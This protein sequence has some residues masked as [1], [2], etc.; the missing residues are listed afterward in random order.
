VEFCGGGRECGDVEYLTGMGARG[1]VDGKTYYLGND[2]LLE[3]IRVSWE[4]R[5]GQFEAL[6]NE[7]KTVL[8]LFDRE[9]V[10]A[11][12]AL[13]D[14]LK[15]GSIEAVAGLK[16]LNIAPHMLTGDN[17]AVAG[18]IAEQAGI[19]AEFVNAE[20]LPAD[21]L[22]AIKEQKAAPRHGGK[23]CVAMIGD[24]INDSPALKEADVG[25]AMGNG[26]DVAIE[27]ADIVLV[28]GDLRA[29]VR[30]FALS[31]KAMR[32]IK[33]NLFWAFF[34]NCIGIPL[35]AGALAFAGV[36]LNPMIASA[37]MSLSS[38]CVVGNALRLTGFLRNQLKGEDSMTKTLK[39]KGMM[40]AH[41]VKHVGDALKAVEG[42]SGAEVDLKKK[43]AVVTLAKDVSD[44]ALIS[45]VTEAG[46]EVE[47]IK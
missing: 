21:K 43:Q 12:F 1:T 46:Y 38:L 3:H 5:R 45:A 27:S 14:T 15:E 40:C 44:E 37:A 23:G 39:V 16:R 30:A 35:A 10:L 28:S 42:V 26:T 2:K 17:R 24:G 41:C 29:A 11:L 4:E 9:R 22:A 6:S 8:F 18:Y 7:G 31:K 47:S 13:A 25:I 19:G 20:V 33:Q 36:T 34:Y 32:I